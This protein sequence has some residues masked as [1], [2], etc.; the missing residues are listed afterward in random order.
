MR[1]AQRRGLRGGDPVG[2]RSSRILCC[3]IRA[4][5]ILLFTA[6]CD[7]STSSAIA[8]GAA[9]STSPVF[10][11]TRLSS[12]A[13]IVRAIDARATLAAE[14]VALELHIDIH[15]AKRADATSDLV[16]PIAPALSPLAVEIDGVRHNAQ[17]LTA[18]DAMPMLE[19]AVR[20]SGDPGV[21]AFAGAAMLVVPDITLAS[22]TTAQVRVA[23]TGPPSGDARLR[24]VRGAAIERTG[25]AW[26]ITAMP[27]PNV[28]GVYSPTHAIHPCQRAAAAG[29]VG[30]VVV[31]TQEPGCVDLVA[32]TAPADDQ[33]GDLGASIILHPDPTVGAGEGG[34]FLLVA[35]PR[36][37]DTLCG[38]PRPREITLVI[39]RSASVRGHTLDRVKEAALGLLARLHPS[40]SLNVIDFAEQ[41]RRLWGKPMPASP[42]RTAEAAQHILAL[43]SGG[44]STA[45][46]ALIDALAQPACQKSL[47]I[48]VLITDGVAVRRAGGEAGFIDA[49]RTSNTATRRIFPVGIGDEINA[50][51]LDTIAT[52]TGGTSAFVLPSEAIGTTLDRL[53]ATLDGPVL[54]RPAVH[55]RQGAVTDLE[56]AHVKDV[57]AGQRIVIAGQYTRDEPID[58]ELAGDFLGEPRAWTI[59]AQP[60]AST[61]QSIAVAR[62]WA[63]R[64]AATLIEQ[65]RACGA[66]GAGVQTVSRR[67]AQTECAAGAAEAMVRLGTDFGVLTEYTA[68]LA[69]NNTPWQHA[70]AEVEGALIHRALRTRRGIAG[71]TQARNLEHCRHAQHARVISHY[72][73]EDLQPVRVTSVLA[74][75]EGVVWRRV[76]SWGVRWIDGSLLGRERL[77]PQAIVP[78][79][80]EAHMALAQRLA[81]QGRVGI[82][83]LA[84][85]IYLDV[86]GTRVL[87]RGRPGG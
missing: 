34:Y 42:E 31:D 3:V 76:G 5:F 86:D 74:L 52:A 10:A 66:S 4:L 54:S 79:G 72:T 60:S 21:L 20:T 44:R 18:A 68:P 27:G 12:D 57:F 47:G 15:N 30:P 82:L 70:S 36:H 19:R 37:M 87:V 65:A 46:P 33:S 53:M 39:D 71:V 35:E 38:D 62:V 69:E 41:P 50:P 2:P 25:P 1:D 28:Q 84:G 83:A 11:P 26:S 67:K 73:T 77:E 56:P 17:H 32:L 6:A 16:I 49:I 8:G 59:T 14:A 78:F 51:L 58:I 9:R 61:E 13:F 40:E 24:I 80:S 45:A 48:V 29:H 22:G 63:T 85:D 7:L 23:L 43:T 75:G 81:E 64:R 55:V